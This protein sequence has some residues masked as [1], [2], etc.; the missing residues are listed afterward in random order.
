[1]FDDGSHH[2][3]IAF[4]EGGMDDLAIARWRLHTQALAGT[5]YPTPAAV[6]EGLLAVQA[7]NYRHTTWAL[8]YRTDDQ[9]TEADVDRLFDDGAVLRTHVLRPT[10]HF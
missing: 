2:G 7:E 10:W 4:M 5:R 9:A 6:I 1:C 8:A 3:R